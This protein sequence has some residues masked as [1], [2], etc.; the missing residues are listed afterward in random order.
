MNKILLTYGKHLFHEELAYRIGQCLEKYQN[1]N[2]KVRKWYTSVS[3]NFHFLDI[4]GIP[5]AYL[6]KLIE[7]ADLYIDLH[8]GETENSIEYTD[9][10][11]ILEVKTISP[12]INLVEFEFDTSETYLR[13]F[14]LKTKGVKTKG[15]RVPYIHS[16]IEAFLVTLIYPKT[17]GIEVM[18]PQSYKPTQFEVEKLS[19]RLYEVLVQLPKDKKQLN[20]FIFEFNEKE[21]NRRLFEVDRI[22]FETFGYR[23]KT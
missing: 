4:T 23:I 8:Q 17:I 1:E 3:L 12:S 16:I 5:E 14:L 6:S 21:K 10:H 19:R 2:L 22:L 13:E 9:K 7:K 18:V 11:G 15:V 20:Q